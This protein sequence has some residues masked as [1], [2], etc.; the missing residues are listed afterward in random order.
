M[1]SAIAVAR[2]ASDWF[3]V[4]G[5]VRVRVRVRDRDE[6]RHRHRDGDRDGVRVGRARVRVRV[7]V[8]RRAWR[9]EPPT[10]RS[11]ALPSGWRMMREMCATCETA[12]RNMTSGI[13]LVYVA[14]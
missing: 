4:R 2:R 11:R 14:L 10:P 6:D 1:N 13:F 7:R 3:R 9:P 8:G 5:T 12:S